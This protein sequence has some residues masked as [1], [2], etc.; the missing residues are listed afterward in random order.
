[1]G[2]ARRTTHRR[3]DDATWVVEHCMEV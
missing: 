3:N 1:V 2:F